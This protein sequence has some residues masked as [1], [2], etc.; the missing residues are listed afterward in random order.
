MRIAIASD[1]WAPQT[2]GV[3]T[4]LRATVDTL[5]RLGHEV[6]VLSPQ[7]LRCIPA[8]SYPEIRLALWPGP[9][10]ARELKA[11][12][13]HAIHIATE[14]PIGMAVRRYCLHRRVPFSTSY[15]TRYPEYLH[16]RWPIPL[17]V[18]YAWLRRFHGAAART[19]VSSHSL[20]TELSA[21]GFGHLHLWRR[22][23]DLQRFHP[24]P[25][26]G[27]LAKLPRPIMAYVGRLAIEKNL[28]AFLGLDVPGTKLVIGDGPQRAELVARHRG[29]VFAGYRFGDELA[30]MLATADVLVFPSLTD[31]FGL[32]MIEALAC[33][34][35][36]AAFPVPG[37]VDVI[38][39]GVT[40]VLHQD[41]A[42]AVR[43][44]LLL[45]RGTCAQ[46]AAAFTWE[47]ATAQFFAG[48]APIP[49]ALR[50]RLAVRRSSVIIARILARMQASG[51]GDAN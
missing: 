44:A 14:G 23:V 46:R 42:A 16:A 5:A 2:N 51:T 35:P 50:A 10:V 22:G 19:F 33:G 25:P 37:P 24:R 48:L 15:H 47:A 1:A 3:V 11:F 9:Y 28:D 6:R 43:S 8:P 49:Q 29:V 20:D 18:S 40:G 38:E 21:R 32:A 26:A 7:G 4:T 17:A 34:V 30:S 41:L 12:R 27:E 31:T 39:Q 13:P 36:V 45:D